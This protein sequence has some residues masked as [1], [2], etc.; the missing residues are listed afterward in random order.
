MLNNLRAQD[1]L[2]IGVLAGTSYYLGDL[3][4]QKQFYMPGFAYGGVGRYVLTDRFAVKGIISTIKIQ[5]KYPDNNVVFPQGDI[6]YSFN[7]RLYDGSAQLEFNFKSYD[8]PFIKSAN[9]SPY[10]SFGIGT[11]FINKRFSTDEDNPEQSNFILSLPFGVGVKYKINDWVRIGAEWSFRKTFV[12]DLDLTESNPTVDPSN[13]YSFGEY[14]ELNYKQKIHNN[15]WY[16]FA[17]V[18]ITF[19]LLKRKTEC[20]AGFRK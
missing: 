7:R 9:F 17:G 14:D 10:L 19:S 20:N 11:T 6:G 16:S 12:D 13:P 18:M 1:K 8:H 5:G 4:P 3:N 15:D 2:E